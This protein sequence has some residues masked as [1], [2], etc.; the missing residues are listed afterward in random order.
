ME[1]SLLRGFGVQGF[2]YGVIFGDYIRI[3]EGFLTNESDLW[4]I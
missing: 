4:M 3:V 1:I 2:I